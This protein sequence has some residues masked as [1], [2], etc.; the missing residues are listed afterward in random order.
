MGSR[1]GSERRRRPVW[2]DTDMDRIIGNLLRTGLAG[3]AA[4]VLVGAVIYFARHGG[5]TAAY[6]IFQGEPAEYRQI[7]GIFGQ[8]ERFRGR[9]FILAGL[10]VLMATPVARVAFSLIAFLRR[11]D[12]VYSLVTGLVLAILLFSLLRSG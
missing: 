2:S 12:V 7:R 4:L 1:D 11:K 8:L 5:E 10:L 3:A 9:G 6:H